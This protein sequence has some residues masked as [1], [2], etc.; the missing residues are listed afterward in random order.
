MDSIYCT[1]TRNFDSKITEMN[2][3]I[4]HA[5]ILD[6]KS[7]Q[8]HSTVD[9]L[10]ENGIITQ[11]GQGLQA[12]EGTPILTQKNLCVSPGWFDTSVSLGEPGYEER[13]T[14]QGGL[15]TAAKSGFTGFALQPNTLPIND[16]QAGIRLV[17][18]L[19]QQHA[20]DLHP[21][22]AL[23]VESKGVD[24]AELYDMQNAGAIAFGDY[25]KYISNANLMKIAMQYLQDFNGNLI[26][27]SQD[28]DLVGPGF[29]H[30]GVVATQLGLK[31]I[32]SLA[33]TIAIERNLHLAKYTDARLH[34]PMLSTKEAVDIIRQAKAEGIAVTCSVSVHHLV[35][36]EEAVTGFNTNARI[37]PPLR[38][39]QDRLALIQGVLDNTIDCI[40]TDH[41]PLDVEVKVLEF[42]KALPGTIGLESAL[43]ALATV[44]PIE[45]ITAK[46]TA[47]RRIFGLEEVTIAEQQPAN[48]T[49]FETESDWVFDTKDIHSKSKN[50]IFNGHPMKGKVVGIYNNSQWIASN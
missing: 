34:I 31:T 13:E 44:L 33:E 1:T 23:T 14:I 43:G 32:P 37:M 46:L 26:A 21:I 22:G 6:P 49:V 19:S 18:L 42:D 29:A 2:L 24:L 17:K 27:H 10:I 48:L 3:L 16:K 15:D 20:V 12:A 9:L 40:T 7:P 25:K 50:A 4:Q 8:H 35:L 41:Q 38:A 11:I 45:V 28:K 30:E 47:G 39:E 36:N 5:R